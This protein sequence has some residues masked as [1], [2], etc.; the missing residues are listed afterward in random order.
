MSESQRDPQ[1][2]IRISKEKLDWLKKRAQSNNRTATAEV[3][4]IISYF[5]ML[6]ENGNV[7]RIA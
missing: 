2:K 1:F 7:P 5:K 6:E 4:F 3:N